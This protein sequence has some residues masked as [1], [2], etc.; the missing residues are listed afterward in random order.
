MDLKT[1]IINYVQKQNDFVSINKLI[2]IFTEMNGGYSLALES[3]KLGTCV[4][5]TGMS[6][7]AAL[8]VQE[9][10]MG[11]ELDTHIGPS[12]FLTYYLEGKVLPYPMH[13]FKRCVTRPHWVPILFSSR[14]FTSYGQG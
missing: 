1:K 3:F 9:L 4:L 12:C 5:W 10:V 8:T 7:E 11:N 2:T 14:K 6:E 13:R